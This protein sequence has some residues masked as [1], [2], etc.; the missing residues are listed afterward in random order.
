MPVSSRLAVAT[1]ILTVM[2]VKGDVPI[3]SEDIAKRAST[4]AAVVRKIIS[5]LG[6]SGI[7]T[8]Q[9]GAKGG[10]HLARAPEQI[11]LLDVYRAVDTQEIFA[12]PNCPPDASCPIGSQI[13]PVLDEV[14]AKATQ[15][16]EAELAAVSIAAIADK[17]KPLPA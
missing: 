12:S 6:R 5:M 3:G 4:N 16:M 8:S 14:K 9:T 7:T 11:T 13:G 15:A 10:T 17:L 1:H 2:A